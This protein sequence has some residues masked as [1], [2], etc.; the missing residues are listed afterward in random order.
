[1]A[2]WTDKKLQQKGKKRAMTREKE[3]GS[4]KRREHVHPWDPLQ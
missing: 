4:T 3:I 2:Q 1:M